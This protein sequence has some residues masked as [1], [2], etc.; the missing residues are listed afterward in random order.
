MDEKKI[1]IP[2]TLLQSQL[3]TQTEVLE[4]AGKQN[5]L[6]IGVPKETTFQEDRVALV[7]HSVAL[8]TAKGHR[9][10]I[11]S[12]AGEKSNFSNHVFAEAGAEIAYDRKKIFQADI[13]IKV[14]PPTLEEI[15]MLKFNQILIS[16]LHLPVVTEEYLTKLKNKK[17]IA[18]AME[19]IKD[20]N[21]TFPVV[22]ILSEIA[23]YSAMLTA[24]EL[25]SHP[26]QGKGM[27]LGGI[28]GVPS[29]KV[30]VLGSG[31]VAEFAIRAALGLGCDIRVFDN[32][33]Y[34]LKKIQ[35]QVSQRLY[36]SA[37]NPVILEKELIT[38]D[39]VIGAVH[40]KSGRA[41]VIISEELVAKMKPGSIIVDVSIDQ[42][43]CFATSELTTHA[44]PTFIKHGVIHY[45]VPN[46]ASRVS[47]TASE[48]VSNI[49]TPILDELG[50][51]GGLDN[52]LQYRFGL[53]NGIYTFKGCLT[54]AYL[55]EKFNMKI[56]D[57]DLLIASKL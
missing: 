11:E 35:T 2:S 5:K 29:A 12:G 50:E 42:G 6:F 39:V 37:L 24:A 3:E 15:D 51:Y 45:C 19:Y 16:P 1:N 14:T 57:L 36:T 23:G 38:A 31:V 44:K 53:R 8:L 17:V 41:P 49:L 34:K 7:P 13:I 40:S 48:A 18:L 4:Y 55:G 52:L 25:L 32:K 21:G 43:G 10:I 47:K 28:S 20:D 56:T 46:I 27:L 9:V 54:N 22:R 33:V 30:V 26:T